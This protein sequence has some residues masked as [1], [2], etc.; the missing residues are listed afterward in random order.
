[1]TR[2]RELIAVLVVA[3]LVMA[4]IA[5]IWYLYSGGPTSTTSTAGPIPVGAFLYLWYGN[6]TTGTGGLGSPGWNSTSCPGGGAVVDTPS[7][8]Y[9]VSDSNATFR[10][11]VN[12]MQNTGINFAV[13]SWWGPFTSGEAG[14]IN[15]ATLDLFRY[16]KGTDSSFRV[17]IMVDAFPGTCSPPLPNLPMSQVYNYIYSNFA[18]PYKQWYFQWQSPCY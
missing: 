5:A 2:R 1:L 8:G 18:A 9:Y 4:S 14:S 13:V 7:T 15:K 3:I 6:A 16:L 11:Q 17:A 12:D 10:R